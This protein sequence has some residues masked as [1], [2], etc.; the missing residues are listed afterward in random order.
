VITDHFLHIGIEQGAE[1]MRIV[2]EVKGGRQFMGRLDHGAD[3]LEALT[4]ICRLKDIQLG[5]LEVLG[6]VQKARMGFYNQQSRAYEYFT[7]DAPLEILKVVGNISLK[8]G[9]PMVHA[10]I[11]LSDSEGKAFGGHLAPGTIVFAAEYLI[12]ELEGDA[13]ER[14]FDKETGLPLWIPEQTD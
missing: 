3:L 6:A 11:T 8:D 12:E 1:I 9:Q 2:R 7:I 10:H 4:G 14:G 13:L 5:R